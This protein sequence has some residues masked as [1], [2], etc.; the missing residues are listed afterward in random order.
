[1]EEIHIITFLTN[2]RNSYNNISNK[3]VMEEIPIITFLTN[4]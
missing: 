3:F 1:M 2:G 4:L